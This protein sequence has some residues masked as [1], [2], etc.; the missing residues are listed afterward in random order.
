M[1][2][3]YD[4]FEVWLN[5]R[6]KWLQSAAC[7]LID[8]KR[9]PNEQEIDALA[10]LCLSEALGKEAEYSNIKAGAIVQAAQRP[11]L[12]INKIFNVIGVNAIKSGAS[13]NFGD[14]NHLTI[15][16][17]ANGTGK[18]SFSR[19]LKQMCGS[20]VTDD[21]SSNI[22]LEDIP[23]TSAQVEISSNGANQN[24][25]WE[26]Q[27]GTLPLLRHIHIFDSKT[28][29]IYMGK[30]EATYEPSRMR[31]ISSLIIICDKVSNSLNQARNQQVCSLPTIPQHIQLTESISW[32]KSLKA[33]TKV[34]E[35]EQKCVFSKELDDERINIESALSQKDIIGRLNTISQTKTTLER[36]SNNINRL[37][38]GLLEEKI[39]NIINAR[40]DADLKRNIANVEARNVFENSQIDG[41]GQEAWMSLWKYAKLFSEQHAYPNN[42]FPFVGEGSHCVL[43]Q[44]ELNTTGKERLSHFQLYVQGSL[45]SEAKNSEKI[46]D[47]LIKDLPILPSEHD[48]IVQMNLL[49]ISENDAK[50]Y[51]AELKSRYEAIKQVSDIAIVPVFEWSSIE[52]SLDSLVKEIN[53]EEKTLLDLQQ[54]GHRQKLENRLKE[55]QTIQWLNQNKSAI[56]NEKTRLIKVAEH[57]K[58]IKLTSTNLLT[59]KNNELAQLELDAGYQKRFE[60]ELKK[61][62]GNR[63]PVKP[64]SK[65]QGKGK[66][67]FGLTLQGNNATIPAERILSEGETRI[68]ALAAFLA[69]ITGSGQNSPFIFDDPIS[70]LDQSFEERVV[71]RLA[72]LAKDRQVII[73]THRLSLL[74]LIEAA[75]KTMKDKASE[76]G[77]PA[78]ITAN[79]ETLRKLGNDA[80]IVAKLSLRDA[81]PAKAISRI[82]GEFLPQLKKHFENGD[83]DLYEREARQICS[84][85]RI[86]VEKCVESILLNDVLVRFRR[87]LQTKGRLSALTKI[88]SNDCNLIDDLMTRYSVYEHSQS[89]ELPS[90]SPDLSQIELDAKMLS[91]WINEFSTRK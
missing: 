3:K 44:Q 10:R 68:V 62:G 19:L 91:D 2:F 51:L 12:R 75:V 43:C 83:A 46:R 1:E 9:L 25:C 71:M 79:T 21:L 89:D 52:T 14:K 56:L 23:P 13:L 90:P 6:P 7:F 87:D 16:Y 31:F 37:K 29:Q 65:K 73:F 64:E 32:F 48:W 57:D 81:K 45:E 18:T 72:E 80:G 49:N 76:H 59:K 61:L 67:T 15:I 38:N 5:E 22:Y 17:G 69:D 27:H 47:N 8:N 4:S 30:N 78:P 20:K 50:Q 33:N 55:L 36:I 35:I 58:A 28:A 66:I 11:I 82:T 42:S 26:P 53:T 70:S 86:L 34:E 54:D 24:I 41:V 88:Q 60:E 74:S 85:F 84:E 63:L 40:V 77:L 39:L